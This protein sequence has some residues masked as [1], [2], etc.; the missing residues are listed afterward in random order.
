MKQLNKRVSKTIA[1]RYVARI[2]VYKRNVYCEI[3]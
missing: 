1:T 3:F 2:H